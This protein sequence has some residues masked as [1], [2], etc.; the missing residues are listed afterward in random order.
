M[1]ARREVNNLSCRGRIGRLS[2]GASNL[3]CGIVYTV[4]MFVSE[5]KSLSR[6]DD[7]GALAV[8]TPDVLRSIVRFIEPLAEAKSRI[9]RVTADAWLR[10]LGTSALALIRGTSVNG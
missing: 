5:S 10:G 8:N 1:P 7:I 4:G 6:H 2:P 9:H 3:Q